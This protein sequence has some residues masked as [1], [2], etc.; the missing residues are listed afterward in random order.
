MLDKACNG[1]STTQK[2]V[3]VSMPRVPDMS[4]CVWTCQIMTAQ[5]LIVKCYFKPYYTH[6]HTFSVH[7]LIAW[8]ILLNLAYDNNTS[9]VHLWL[10]AVPADITECQFNLCK[11]TYNTKKVIIQQI[12]TQLIAT[13]SSYAW[14]QITLQVTN[15]LIKQY[16][17]TRKYGWKNIWWNQ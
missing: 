6:M 5:C 13:Q 12:C 14:L 8:S 11:T 4:G 1:Y 15:T 17:I 16:H 9:T 2:T 7:D 10:V 3:C